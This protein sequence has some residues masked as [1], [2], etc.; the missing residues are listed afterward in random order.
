MTICV[1][2]R[3]SVCV[4]ACLLHSHVLESDF[5]LCFGSAP[6]VAKCAPYLLCAKNGHLNVLDVRKQEAFTKLEAAGP[7]RTLTH[8][9]RKV[10]SGLLESPAPGEQT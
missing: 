1:C 10:L 2:V 4:Y 8:A 9:T 5:C 6:K 7:V 3:V